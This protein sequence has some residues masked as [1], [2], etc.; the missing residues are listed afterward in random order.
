MRA[1]SQVHGKHK[2][3]D[4]GY[5]LGVSGALEKSL[6][7]YSN[8]SGMVARNWIVQQQVWASCRSVLSTGTYDISQ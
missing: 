3:A 4:R 7:C 2:L 1:D 5:A 6:A 8:R